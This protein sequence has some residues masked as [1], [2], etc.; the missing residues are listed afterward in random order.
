MIKQQFAALLIKMVLVSLLIFPCSSL[1]SEQSTQADMVKLNSIACNR[2]LSKNERA[3]AIT[4]I[5]DNPDIINRK[6]CEMPRFLIN[7]IWL[8]E[9]YI[10]YFPGLC[11]KLPHGME[12]R[13]A[14]ESLFCMYLFPAKLGHSTTPYGLYFTL[15][16]TFHSADPAYQFLKGNCKDAT[17]INQV[18]TWRPN[19]IE[20]TST[21]APKP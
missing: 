5:F 16:G 20:Y 9:C 21:R 11:G 3:G 12:W 6:S 13:P 18:S 4:R 19:G 7:P 1:A 14:D 17:T 15:T 2:L 10:R 8:S